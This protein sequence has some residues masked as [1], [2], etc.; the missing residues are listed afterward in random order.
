MS[1]AIRDLGLLP[2]DKRKSVRDCLLAGQRQV[3]LPVLA[4]II[5]GYAF[6]FLLLRFGSYPNRIDLGSVSGLAAI[7]YLILGP[8][9]IAWIWWSATVPK[10]RIWALRTVDD[11]AAL[12]DAAVK[13]G[14]IWPRDWIFEKT[15][16]K[17][18]EQRTLETALLRARDN[19]RQSPIPPSP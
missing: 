16:F 17:S 4:I 12:E 1:E 6:P 9:S 14:L 7:A 18:A 13:S 8:A 3:N 11:W 19:E 2:P 15:E 10:W 5:A